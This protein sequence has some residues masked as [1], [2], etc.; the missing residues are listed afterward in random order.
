MAAVGGVVPP[1]PCRDVG[2]S[3]R[4]TIAPLL[5]I[6]NAALAVGAFARRFFR[7]I[8]SV[9]VRSRAR[10]RRCRQAIFGLEE[11][12]SLGTQARRSQPGQEGNVNSRSLKHLTSLT[13]EDLELTFPS[14]S[15]SLVV[16]WAPR[17]T[18]SDPQQ[19]P[20]T[21]QPHPHDQAHLPWYPARRRRFPCFSSFVVRSS[22]ITISDH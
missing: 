7:R 13:P 14:W 18:D 4:R 21:D 5:R 16:D 15:G 9:L 20:A 6:S 8:P 22:S 3:S 12:V 19:N 2:R 11:L 17:E 1:P 10:P